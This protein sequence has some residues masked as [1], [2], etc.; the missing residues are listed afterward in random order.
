MTSTTIKVASA[1][2]D[3]LRRLAKASGMTQGEYIE[4]LLDQRE[5]ADFWQAIEALDSTEVRAAI[6]SDGDEPS[7][8]YGLEDETMAR[9]ERTR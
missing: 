5:E 9:D 3:R 1:T 7:E 8:D 6:A 2:H 4:A